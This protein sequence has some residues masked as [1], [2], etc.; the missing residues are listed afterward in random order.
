MFAMFT[1]QMI[2][3][4]YFS[5]TR[6]NGFRICLQGKRQYKVSAN[7]GW[8]DA[9]RLLGGRLDE[10]A[11]CRVESRDAQCPQIIP[12]K[13]E[14]TIAFLTIINTQN[15][16]TSPIV[17]TRLSTTAGEGLTG[18]EL[19]SSKGDEIGRYPGDVAFFKTGNEI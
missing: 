19:L 2:T 15:M 12:L 11:R 10:W 16:H 7:T 5:V 4:L 1:N 13:W 3:L 9:M 14:A 18:W 17:K 6:D 8:F